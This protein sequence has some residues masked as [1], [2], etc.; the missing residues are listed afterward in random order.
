MSEPSVTIPPIQPIPEGLAERAALLGGPEGTL[1]PEAIRGF[2]AEQLAGQDLD[3]KSVCL[4]IPDGT[5]SVPLPLVLPAIHEALAG[6]AASV[7]VLIALG[8]HAAMSPEAIDVLLGS[9]ERGAAATYPGWEVVNHAWHDEEQIADLGEIPAE[10]IA[11]LTGGLLTDVPMRVQINRLVAESDVNLIVGP[12][13]PHEVV[14]FSGGNKYFFPGCSVHDVIDIS[15]WV[16]ALI[17]ASRIIGTLGITPVRQ[18]IDAASEL[19]QA[20]KLAFTMDVKEGGADL[21]AIAFGDPQAAWA[22]CA[23]ISAQTHITYVEKP[24][25][26]IVAI[27]PEMYDDMWTGAK[28]FYKSEPVCADG[29][30]VIIYAPHITEVAA[31]H[32]GI[33]EIGYHNIEYFTKQWDRFA[34]HPWGELAHSTHVTGLGTYDPET[35]VEEQRVNRYFATS[36]SAEECAA[37]NVL[38]TDPA[39][40]DLDALRADPETLVIDHA[41]EVLFRLA[42]EKEGV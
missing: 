37:H 17:T 39:S 4:I 34:G 20:E 33:R 1:A 32:P 41:G 22:A 19:I 16:G 27:V 26:R 42:S 29:G 36:I 30:D 2:V 25:R 3:G 5:R 23:K 28:G 31:M 21:G 15:H 11:E 13:F 9:T 10:R 6:R 18:L 24:Y 8:T 38:Y 7:T 40:L 12:V 35:G 14:G